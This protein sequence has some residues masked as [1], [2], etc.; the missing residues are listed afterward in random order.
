[1]ASNPPMSTP[2]SLPAPAGI[3]PHPRS[4]RIAAY[5]TPQ[6]HWDGAAGFG[7]AIA[8][9]A[10]STLAPSERTTIHWPRPQSTSPRI[11]CITDYGFR[12]DAAYLNNPTQE[13]DD[14]EPLTAQQQQGSHVLVSN[15]SNK[16]DSVSAIHNLFSGNQLRLEQSFRTGRHSGGYS[17]TEIQAFIGS[18]AGSNLGPWVRIHADNNNKPGTRLR[19]FTEVTGFANNSTASFTSSEGAI[20]LNPNTKYWLVFGMTSAENADRYRIDNSNGN[21]DLLWRA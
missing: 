6:S 2:P 18:I 13:E 16:G 5:S 21:I 20:T 8:P 15:L 1:M 10:I 11:S 4:G 3:L 7:L 9:V 14:E 17:V 19:S 12:T